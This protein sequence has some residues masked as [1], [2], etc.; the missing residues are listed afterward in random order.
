M[1]RIIAVCLSEAKGMRKR[2]MG[3]GRL[4]ANFGLEG[5]A[6]ASSHWHRQVSLLAMESINKMRSQGLDVGPGDFAENI[7]TEGLEL[8]TLPIGTRLRLGPEAVGEVTQIGKECHN[9]CAIYEQAGD[10]VMP[11]EGIF[12]KVLQGG[13][14]NNGDTIGVDNSI[15]T[16]GIIIASD[17]GAAGQRQD[18]SGPAAAKTLQSIGVLAVET[19]IVPDDIEQLA[20][21]MRRMADQCAYDLI[22]TSGGTGFS[23]RDITPEATLSVIERQAPGLAEAMRAASLAVSPH[24]ML[25]R[26]VAGIRGRSL[27]INLPGSPKA[28]REC[29]A[30]ILPAL[31]HGIE[32]LRGQVK[33]CGRAIND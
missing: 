22:L 30:A 24:A 14:I 27:I 13:Q 5:D 6:H 2:D 4:I 11:R 20:Q 28:V 31:P 33:D 29:L 32:V 16:A 8:Y 7:T 26:A 12:I 23:P 17:A 9:R 21:T 25:S 18:K 15:I 19:V 10:C 1:A 3:A